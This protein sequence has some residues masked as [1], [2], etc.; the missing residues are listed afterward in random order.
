MA[1]QVL[2]HLR[3]EDY[4]HPADRKALDSLEKM[5]GIATLFKK[6]NEYGID[7]L[8]RL[9]CVGSDIRV[10]ENNF[11]ELYT[12]FQDTCKIL[13]VPQPELYLIRG[14][15]H[16]ETFTYGVERS[17]VMINLEGMEELTPDEWLYLFG[18]ELSLIHI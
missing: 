9:Q 14:N 7:R 5:P 6:V 11:P 12:A 17:I 8:L 1:R 15:G 4:E 18:H 10:S 2:S 16:I 3:P 13:A